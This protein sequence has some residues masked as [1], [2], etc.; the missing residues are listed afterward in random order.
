VFNKAFFVGMPPSTPD[1]VRDVF[2]AAMEKTCKNPAYIEEMKKYYIEV[3][4]LAPAAATAYW[5]NVSALFD[6]YGPKL[7]ASIK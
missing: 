5:K 7:R 6:S 4:Y 1:A 3:E 2:S